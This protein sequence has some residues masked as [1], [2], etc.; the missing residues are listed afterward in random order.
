[1][2]ITKYEILALKPNPT[3]KL[4]KTCL[5]NANYRST[6]WW[7]G[8]LWWDIATSRGNR[9]MVF[10]WPRGVAANGMPQPAWTK[11]YPALYLRKIS[12]QSKV[13]LAVPYKH[14]EPDEV[15]K[16]LVS[17]GRLP[18]DWKDAFQDVMRAKGD[19]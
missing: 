7:D 5:T 2:P 10:K 8:N 11:H 14:F 19:K 4:Y 9:D 6:R 1:M 16:Y 13:R 12:D 18:A 15:L 3:P 17:I